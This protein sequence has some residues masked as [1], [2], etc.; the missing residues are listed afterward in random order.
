MWT[1]IGIATGGSG[2]F[3]RALAAFDRAME[4][5]DRT[6]ATICYYV[7]AL[8]RSGRRDE[9][10]RRLDTIERSGTFVPPSSLAIA[11]AGLGERDRAMEQLRNAFVDRDPLLQYIAVE[12]YLDGLK[13]DSR[14][15][16]IVAQMGSSRR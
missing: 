13:S 1:W 7:H 5:G 16:A 15:Q 9:A 10:L 11:Y 2:D 8:A 4:L 12:S 14:F 6:A 3:V